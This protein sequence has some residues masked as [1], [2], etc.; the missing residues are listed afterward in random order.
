MRKQLVLCFTLG[1]MAINAIAQETYLDV[2][3]NYTP[4][5]MDF[6]DNNKTVKDFKKGYWGLQAGASLQLGVTDYFSVVPELYFV[7][8]GA[9]LEKNNPL[10]GQETRIRFNTID[11]PVLARLHLCDF[12]VNAG[13]VA[14]YNLGGHVKAKAN[15]ELPDSKVMMDFGSDESQY[16]RWD[17]GI[18]FGLGYEIQLKKSRLLLDLRYHYGMVDMGNGSDIYNRY[19]NMNILLAKKWKNNPLAKARKKDMA[20]WQ[21]VDNRPFASENN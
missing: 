17:A 3:I 7:M 2:V 14:S 11:L 16:S 8:K 15:G 19:F 4:T 21:D 6:G 1:L 20:L 12:Y 10:T 13:P 18:Q 9:K 5:T